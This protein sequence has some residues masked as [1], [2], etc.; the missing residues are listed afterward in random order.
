MEGKLAVQWDI[1]ISF[2]FFSFLFVFVV[3]LVAT[4]LI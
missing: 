1:G 2:L 3:A 4:Q